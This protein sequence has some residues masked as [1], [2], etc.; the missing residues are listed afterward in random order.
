MIETSQKRDGAEDLGGMEKICPLY[1]DVWKKFALFMLMWKTFTNPM[2]PPRHR[3][4]LEGNLKVESS[5][6]DLYTNKDENCRFFKLSAR[7]QISTELK[8]LL[9]TYKDEELSLTITGHS[10]GSTLAILSAY[11]IVETG[12]NVLQDTRAVPVT[13]FSFSG[14]PS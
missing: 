2:R 4:H 10:L 3:R 8:R 13:V 9:E 5:F 7:E 14:P 12:L 1:A 6:I 11:D